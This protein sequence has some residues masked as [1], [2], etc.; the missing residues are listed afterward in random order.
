MKKQFWE[1][2]RLYKIVIVAHESSTGP[3]QELRDFLFSKKVKFIQFIAH[4]LI[5]LK[6]H[7]K[8]SSRYTSYK[9]GKVIKRYTAFHWRIPEALL[10]IKDVLYT[11]IWGLQAKEPFDIYFGADPLNA[12]SGILLRTLGKVKKVVYYNIDYTPQRFENPLLNYI[13]HLID[14]ICC[15]TA[16]ANWIG[17]ERTTLARSANGVS[18][19]RTKNIIV[20]RDGTHSLKTSVRDSEINKNTI[21]YVGYVLEKQ[22]IDLVLDSLPEIK[23]EIPGIKFIVIG[24]GPYLPV[25]EEKVQKLKLGDIVEFRGFVKS[26]KEVQDIVKNC[27]IGVAPYVEDKNSFTYYSTSGKPVLYLGSGIPVVLTEV[28]EI[29]K[30][31]HEKKAGIMIN[32]NKKKFVQAVLT[33]LRDK[34][35]FNEYREN[36]RVFGKELDWSDIFEKSVYETVK[37]FDS[38]EDT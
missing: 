17:T 8:D 36:A 4:P 37:S 26:D 23:K 15:Y 2:L 5:Y 28:P 32:Y 6:E 27:G 31:I 34:K 1:K 25:L 13:Y 38:L 16:D 30:E 21:V 33:I 20:V 35:E 9:D 3:P 24:K 12:F 7:Y 10:Y 11:V 19:E 29:A 14:K 22:G 18:K